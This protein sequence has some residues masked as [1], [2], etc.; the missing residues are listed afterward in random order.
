MKYATYDAYVCFLRGARR[1]EHPRPERTRG[2]N[3]GRAH[4]GER[5]TLPAAFSFYTIITNVAGDPGDK[6]GPPMCLTCCSARLDQHLSQQT[7]K[8]AG[9]HSDQQVIGRQPLQRVGNRAAVVIHVG[10]G[11]H[12]DDLETPPRGCLL[13]PAPVGM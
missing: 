10:F 12:V 4:E 11:V 3:T 6:P 7:G 1:G 9:R 8:F 2:Q 13:H 5:T